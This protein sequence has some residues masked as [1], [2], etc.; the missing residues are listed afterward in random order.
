MLSG[1][2]SNG[3][4]VTMGPCSSVSRSLPRFDSNVMANYLDDLRSMKNEVYEV[5]AALLTSLHGRGA[6]CLHQI[7]PL[8]CLLVRP[9]A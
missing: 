3:T 9:G 2:M 1:H 6:C 8:T 7:L 4:A 5:R